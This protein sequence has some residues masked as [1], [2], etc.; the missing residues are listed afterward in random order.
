MQVA[1]KAGQFE[2]YEGEFIAYAGGQFLDHGSNPSQLRADCTERAAT[3]GIE[4]NRIL[5]HYIESGVF[6]SSRFWFDCEMLV[7]RP[8]TSVL[9]AQGNALGIV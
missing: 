5:I 7:F 3:L 6:E 4:T 8:E 9:S 2:A 1:L